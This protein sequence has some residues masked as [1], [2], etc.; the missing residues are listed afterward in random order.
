MYG[1]RYPSSLLATMVKRV[2]TDSDDDKN[3]FIK[4]NPTRAGVIKACLNRKAR[5]NGKE[6]DIGMALDKS[7]TN[8]AY[9][10]GRLFAVLERIQEAANPGLNRTITDAYF[11]SA[12]ARPALIFP[13]LVKL[14]QNHMRKLEYARYWNRQIGEIVAMLEGEYPDTLPLDDQGRFIIGYYQQKYAPSEKKQ[15]A[16]DIEKEGN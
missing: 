1:Y 15:D 5:L 4:L 9:L 11:A 7:N 3:K 12:S 13:R 10:C 6:E 2:Q 16:T 14:S 8:P